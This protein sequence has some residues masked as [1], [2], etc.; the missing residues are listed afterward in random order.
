LNLDRI[1]D[2]ETK[3]IDL[4]ILTQTYL[5]IMSDLEEDFMNGGSIP[6]PSNLSPISSALA[7]Q[8]LDVQAMMEGDEEDEN[9]V[10][11]EEAED[12]TPAEAD[13][14]GLSIPISFSGGGAW[15]DRELINAFDAAKEEFEVCPH[16]SF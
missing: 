13:L 8:G 16:H 4:S 1:V 9:T 3:P 5:I 10:Y 12:N 7:A 6:G 14:T 2:I 11:Q 15:D